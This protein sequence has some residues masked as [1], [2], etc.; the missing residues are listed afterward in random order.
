MPVQLEWHSTMPV[1]QVTC[2]GTLS[3]NDYY[4]LNRRRSELLK[5]QEGDAL[6]LVDLQQ[7]A[8]FPD[9][10]VVERGESALRDNRIQHILAVLPDDL[11]RRVART[12]IQNS[13]LRVLLFPTITAALDAAETLLAS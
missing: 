6:L 1:L 13:A 8:G 7:L 10:A 4:A 5:T 3:A 11:Y 9:A 12:V 2:T